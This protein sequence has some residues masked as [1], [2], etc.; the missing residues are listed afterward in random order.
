MYIIKIRIFTIYKYI[1]K[2]LKILKNDSFNILNPNEI[3]KESW[4][5]N[6]KDAVRMIWWR[7]ESNKNFW[8]VLWP[9]IVEKITWKKIQYS[10]WICNQERYMTIGSILI[11]SNQNTIIWG[12]GLLKKWT[13]IK[14][15]LKICSVRWPQTRKELLKQWIE[16]P[17]SYWDPWLLISKYYKPKS[18]KEY[19][20]WII[21]HYIDYCT[22][23]EK[24][25]D[26][27]IIIINLLDPIEKVLE[28]IN[29]C[30]RTISSSLH[31]IIVS[32]SYSIP[33]MF[34]KFSEKLW[35]DN[36]KFEDYFMSVGLEFYYPYDYSE[37]IPSKEYI[38]K[39]I[40]SDH[41]KKPII[42]YNEILD[43]CPFLKYASKDK[44]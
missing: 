18:K 20:L 6:N 7:W 38:I 22:I 33:C 26:E 19:K 1:I 21:P 2:L 3:L 5:R 40:D 23:K 15:P 31:G 36:I 14:K 43:C 29:S 25:T 13:Q 17:E 35:S 32:H 24:L 4:I 28:D 9:Y 27:E 12:S 10:N 30:E 37:K 44:E 34:V 8:D 16:C 39:K 11:Y 41:S 42:N